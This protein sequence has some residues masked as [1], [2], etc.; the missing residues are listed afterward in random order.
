M[1]SL[2]TYEIYQW[3]IYAW[4]CIGVSI[5]G[6]FSFRDIFRMIHEKM[7]IRKKQKDI[8]SSKDVIIK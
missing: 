2:H 3:I 5:V 4:F 6:F 8:G 1:L 7:Q